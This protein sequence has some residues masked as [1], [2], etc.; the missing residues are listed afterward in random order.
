M[1]FLPQSVEAIVHAELCRVLGSDGG[2][3]EDGAALVDI[4]VSSLKRLELCARVGLRLGMAGDPPSTT[5]IETVRDFVRAFERHQERRAHG[6]SST[7]P[8]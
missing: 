8:S 1:A 7:L 4:G 2:S 3:F 5:G 6:R